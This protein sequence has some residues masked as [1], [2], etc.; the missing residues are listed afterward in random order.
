MI[1]RVLISVSCNFSFGSQFGRNSK[2]KRARA[3]GKLACADGQPSFPV[4]TGGGGEKGQT[5]FKLFEEIGY[6]HLWKLGIY[7]VTNKHSKIKYYQPAG[8][9][10]WSFKMSNQK[11]LNIIM[12]VRKS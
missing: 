11:K 5:N 2:V 1:D 9:A 8:K 6:K 10:G 4:V 7:D 3:G 12:E